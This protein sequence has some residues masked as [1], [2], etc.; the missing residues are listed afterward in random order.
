[1]PSFE[2]LRVVEVLSERTGLQRLRLDDGSRAYVLTELI[3]TV[4]VGDEVV[5]NT[6]AVDLDL[7]T[8][9][10]HVVHWNLSRR[11]L[12]RRGPGHIMKIRYTS[13][14]TDSGSA[15]EHLGG[16]SDGRVPSLE[17]CPVLVGGLHS[18]VAVA[19]AVIARLRPGTRV[20]YVMTDGAALPLAL[21]DLV[22]DLVERS[23]L[24]GTV[25]AGH[26]FGGDLEAVS[27]PSALALAVREQ[28]AE[29][30][31]CAMG[32]GV[33]GTDSPLG[34]SA[35]E[36]S[37]ILGVAQRLGGH[38]IAVARASSADPRPRHL[39]L[40]HHTRTA[41]A[42]CE[43]VEVV[44][45]PELGDQAVG[46]APHRTLVVEPPDP[47]AILADSGLRVTTMGRGPSD[48]PLFF[49][50]VAAAASRAADLA[51]ARATVSHR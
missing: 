24:S 14:Q 34:T 27:V 5:V 6:T 42:L 7:G 12:R 33:V 15:E 49:R 36:V 2:T 16:S 31:I 25:T 17:G 19:A 28:R 43:A 45:P 20:S 47:A 44:L 46:L 41:L 1:M 35:V 10:W 11:S 51:R 38:A 23:L 39:G 9:G 22:A 21:S 13:L 40:S 32:P 30:V 3:G 26:A 4:A 29:V 8:G 48:D 37:G 50:S 18:Q